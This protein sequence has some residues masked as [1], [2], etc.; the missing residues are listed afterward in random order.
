[1]KSLYLAIGLSFSLSLR[2]E[3]QTSLYFDGESNREVLFQDSVSVEEMMQAFYTVMNPSYNHFP[4]V[5]DQVEGYC[6]YFDVSRA[7]CPLLQD[8]TIR[9]YWND[10]YMRYRPSILYLYDVRRVG[11]NVRDTLLYKQL[12]AQYG[13]KEGDG[14]PA[15]WLN[16]MIGVLDKPWPYMTYLVSPERSWPKILKGHFQHSASSYVPNRT[17]KR[18]YNKNGFYH[19]EVTRILNR[20]DGW[21]FDYTWWEF[22]LFTQD[23]NS[24]CPRPSRNEVKTYYSFLFYAD[25]WGKYH[26]YTLLPKKLNRRDRLRVQQLSACLEHFPPWL[27]GP[28]FTADG[29]VLPGR[30]ISASYGNEGWKLADYLPLHTSFDNVRKGASGE[31][32]FFQS[33]PM[34]Y[35]SPLVEGGFY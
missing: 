19:D 18:T 28:L 12:A 13:E 1:M 26:V 35:F 27:F 24:I 34:G 20:R 23:V 32:R 5:S 10:R 14:I 4:M 6:L 2:V 9:C 15:V 17:F 33:D 25:C 8:S 11:K 31:Y 16:G 29:R 3:A 21:W 7:N 22:L 30:Y